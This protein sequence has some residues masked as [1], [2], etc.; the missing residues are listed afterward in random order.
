MMSRDPLDEPD[1]VSTDSSASS[2][3]PVPDT[4][5]YTHT[6]YE[7]TALCPIGLRPRMRLAM[8]VADRLKPQSPHQVA[9][10]AASVFV[11]A[12][13]PASQPR[14]RVR[15]FLRF[16]ARYETGATDGA[17]SMAAAHSRRLLSDTGASARM[18][19]TPFYDLKEVSK[20]ALF[21]AFSADP[22]ALPLVEL[23]YI[24]AE[25]DKQ[26]LGFVHVQPTL[27]I[28]L[29]QPDAAAL[30]IR[31]EWTTEEHANGRSPLQL[32]VMALGA[33][34]APDA[35]VAL[36]NELRGRGIVVI[37]PPEAHLLPS[38]EWFPIDAAEE[39]DDILQRSSRPG[40]PADQ[41]GIDL[42]LTSAD[43]AHLF[44]LP[45]P[46]CDE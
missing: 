44:P 8:G 1:G 29:R 3:P 46:L 30:S 42:H 40:Q 23:R 33:A 6:Q 19:L 27:D 14:N 45:M 15:T 2:A 31:I 18:L 28:L 11:V 24:C 39:R 17:I 9:V 12:A 38:V 7:I 25:P 37:D 4:H 32:R 41:R 20:R 13:A 10:S 36:S 35:L 21:G 22:G 5:S 26:W 43:I 34:C 16:G